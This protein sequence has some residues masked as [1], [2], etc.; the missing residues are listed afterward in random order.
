MLETE[1][2]LTVELARAEE[3]RR[4]VSRLEVEFDAAHG[5][6]HPNCLMDME[7]TARLAVLR[8]LGFRV[9][10]QYEIDTARPGDLP[11]ISH[12]AVLCGGIGVQLEDGFVCK[13]ES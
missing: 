3:W 8:D 6:G 1:S 11:S 2:R 13:G 12:W 4:A 10:R 7:P 9:K 5:G